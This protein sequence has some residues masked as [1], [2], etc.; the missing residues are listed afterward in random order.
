MAKAI[1]E[2]SPDINLNISTDEIVRASVDTS[3]A[4]R[5]NKYRVKSICT[6]MEK[7]NV[8]MND[9]EEELTEYN[10]R[11]VEMKTR[12]AEVQDDMKKEYLSQVENLEN[13][14]NL[15]AVKYGKLKKPSG[16]VWDDLKVA[17]EEAWS[18]L[19]FY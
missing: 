16:D 1:M 18:E 10:T 12:V 3:G 13:I 2:T 17:I 6:K 11:F 8:Y 19:E 9:F 4:F 14:R 7:Q 5:G 15:Y